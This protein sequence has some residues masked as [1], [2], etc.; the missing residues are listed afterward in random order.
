MRS[1]WYRFIDDYKDEIPYKALSVI[2]EAFY[3]YLQIECDDKAFS[4]NAVK[5]CNWLMKD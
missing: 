3:W 4:E 2:L 1:Q 5:R